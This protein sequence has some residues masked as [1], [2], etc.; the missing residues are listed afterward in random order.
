M[1]DE[2]DP[3]IPP[4]EDLDAGLVITPM[5][6]KNNYLWGW[7]IMDRNGNPIPLELYRT[8]IL[9]AQ[10]RVSLATDLIL[11]PTEFV[12]RQ[13][14]YVKDYSNFGY[15]TLYHRPVLELK[16]LK[17]VFADY[18]VFQF[19]NEWLRVNKEEGQLQIFPTFGVLGS[20]LITR[21][22]DWLSVFLRRWTY[23]P[24]L[25]QIEYTAGFE[26]GKVPH[27][28]KD[29]IAKEAVIGISETFLDLVVGPGVGSSS[30]SVDGVSKSTSILQ[31]HP[32]IR[33]YRA[34]VKFFYEKVLET[35]RGRDI[36]IL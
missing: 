5:E 35:I 1:S 36:A 4:D 13:D 29:I 28:L 9:A 34:D 26:K 11:V 12:D 8:H 6:L 14:Y 3:I 21:G 25:W 27:V 33:Q 17:I 30:I 23:A 7:D 19:P 15:L 20:L 32:R 10:N 16:S 22:G 31:D 2:L 18:N 24:Q